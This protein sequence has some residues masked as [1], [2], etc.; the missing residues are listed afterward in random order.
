MSSSAAHAP[1]VVA[2]FCLLDEQGRLLVVRKRGTTAFMLPGGKLEP[3]E[4]ALA[5]A[6]REVAEEVGLTDLVAR[7]LGHWTAAAANEPGRTVVST[8]FVADLPR[9]SA[10]AAV[11][12]VVAGEIEELCWLDPADA[13]PAVPGGHGLAPLT[14]DAV[15]PALRALR[16]GTAP[17]VAVVGIGAD[18]DLTAAGRDRV[19]AAPSVLGAQRHLALLPPPTGRA[20][21]QVRESW[22]RPFRESLVDLLASHPD[23]VVLASGDPLVS[24]VG[25]TLVDLLGA[26]RVEVLPAVSSVALARA[27]M[28]WGEESC[29]V[30]TV[31]GRRVERVLREVAPGRRVVVLSSDAT[32]PAVL[33]ALLVATGQG[34][35]ALTVLADL[36]APTQAR[37]DTTA[38]GFAARDDLVDLPALNLVCV[39]VPRSAAAH[40]IGWVAGLPDDAFEHDG[41]LTK[42][43]LRAAA[44]ARLAPCPGELLWDVGAGAGSVGVEWMRAHPTCRTI[45]IEQHPDR[46]ARIGRN[47]A[48]LGVPDLVVVEGGAPGALADLPAPNAVFVGGGATAHGL[49]EECRERLRPGGRLVV[50]GVTLE[51]EAVLAE[52]YAGHG[53]ELTRLAV[54]HAAPVGRFTGWTP[55]RTV[56]QW[57]WTK[58][59]A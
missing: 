26:D 4:T 9:D 25:A 20:E 1:I 40:G 12:P 30:V 45:A 43:D 50:H 41:Q 16:A 23:A 14:R 3:G 29:A 5:A 17:R 27:A 10:G 36:G 37:W 8:V 35:A 31:V 28:G 18:G 33:A 54:E 15:L 48:R 21:H 38:A 51:T 11:V 7:P 46:V 39:E 49:L 19:L 6:R 32:T 57:T 34:A 55:A 52:A 2:A 56:T 44:L 59:H 24:G 13:D 58:P 47:A 42:R 22:G 53:G